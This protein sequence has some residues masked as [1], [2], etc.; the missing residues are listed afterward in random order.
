MKVFTKLDKAL[1][2]KAPMST[3]PNVFLAVDYAAHAGVRP[4]TARERLQM[5]VAAG[6]VRRVRTQRNGRIYDAWEYIT[7]TKKATRE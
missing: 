5:M 6:K 7:H 3:G 2:T 4:R 1:P